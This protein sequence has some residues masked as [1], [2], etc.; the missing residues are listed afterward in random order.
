MNFTKKH[1]LL[2]GIVLAAVS[3]YLLL[4]TRKPAVDPARPEIATARVERGPLRILVSCTGRVASRRDVEIKAK[5]SGV[6][7]ALLHEVNDAVHAGDLLLALDPAQEER[8][9]KQAEIALTAAE[10]R[11]AQSRQRAVVAE[12]N[13]PAAHQREETA[14]NAARSADQD[15]RLRAEKLH[16]LLGKGLV[17]NAEV[18]IAE[19]AALQAAAQQSAAEARV[20]ELEAGELGL[21]LQRQEIALANNQIEAARLDLASARGRLSD[22]RVTSPMDGVVTRRAAQVGQVVASGLGGGTTVM[23]ISDLSQLFVLA[24]VDESDIGTVKAGQPAII[25]SDAYPGRRFEGRVVEL[26]SRGQNVS[27]VVTFEARIELLGE[28]RLLLKPEMTANVQIVVE[29]RD[30][31]L[32]IPARALFRSGEHSL[33]KVLAAGTIEDRPVDPGAGDGVRQEISRG[34]KEG[35]VVVVR[36]AAGSGDETMEG[37]EARPGTRKKFWMLGS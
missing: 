5:G 25:T 32:L 27:N 16:R 11:L 34:L 31:V 4:Q 1:L 24:A 7:V 26:A 28:D 6:I 20:K 23:T 8:A 2:P 3:G 15:A 14:L 30:G 17:S 35:E 9:V 21:E 37:I 12:K 19:S 33:V 18:E 36:P 10:L 22:L 13:L 29:E